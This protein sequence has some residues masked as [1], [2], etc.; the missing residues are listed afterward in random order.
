MVFTE[1]L[2]IPYSIIIMEVMYRLTLT[3]HTQT[4]P[5]D[6]LY[7]LHQQIKDT[8]KVE[9]IDYSL[10][11]PRPTTY[12]HHGGYTELDTSQQEATETT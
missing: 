9:S 1:G 2:T 12:E 10:L 5:H 4:D 7:T 6:L 8:V 11:S 3:I